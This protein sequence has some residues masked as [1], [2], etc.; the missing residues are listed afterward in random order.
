K[1]L[2]LLKSCNNFYSYVKFAG[3]INKLICSLLANIAQNSTDFINIINDNDTEWFNNL[4]TLPPKIIVRFIK[5]L[6]AF[7]AENN[8]LLLTRFRLHYLKTVSSRIS[9]MYPRG[10]KWTSGHGGSRRALF[11]ILRIVSGFGLSKESKIGLEKP[12]GSLLNQEKLDDLLVS[13][14]GGGVYYVKLMKDNVAFRKLKKVGWLI[15]QISRR[16]FDGPDFK[17]FEVH[18]CGSE[19]S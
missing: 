5:N 18:W 8:N 13:S 11:G 12:I 15:D 7:G 14:T 17:I 3:L 10:I 19:L 16:D 6:E 9:N 2:Q 4:S 1:I